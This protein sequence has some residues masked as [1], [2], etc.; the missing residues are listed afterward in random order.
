MSDNVFSFNPVL[1]QIYFTDKS[2]NT[3]KLIRFILSER[4]QYND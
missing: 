3:W 4:K 2:I 1:N